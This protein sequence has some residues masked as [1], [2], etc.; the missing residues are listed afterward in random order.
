MT[1]SIAKHIVYSLL[2]LS[3]QVVILN[4][5]NISQYI[6]PMLYPIVILSQGRNL[7]AS[8]LLTIGFGLGLIMDVFSNTGGAHTVACTVIAYIRP[9]FLS[10]FGP[11]DMG[12]EHIK[13]SIF[14]FGVK[15][16]ALFVFFTLVI[17]HILFFFLEAFS[18]SNV[19]NTFLRIF[20][21]LIF[22]WSLSMAIQYLFVSKEK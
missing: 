2:I 22:S 3:F 21:S 4:N 16:Y 10:S 11:M 7:N 19:L 14:N 18:F 9:L 20:G 5:L 1:K 17:H 6:F 13:P 8:L 12:S 15:K